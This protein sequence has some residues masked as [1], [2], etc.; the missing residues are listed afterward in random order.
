MKFQQLRYLVVVHENG[1]NITSAARQLRASQPGVSRQLKLLEAELEFH[2]FERQGSAKTRKR[3]RERGHARGSGSHIGGLQSSAAR[4][5]LTE[6]GT[7]I[8]ALR[9]ADEA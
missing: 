1:L 4:Q 7:R 6:C 8:T 5:S 3:C 9:A 2:L